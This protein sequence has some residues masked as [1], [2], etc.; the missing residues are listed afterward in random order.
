[1]CDSCEVVEV[2]SDDLL[3]VNIQSP[4]CPTAFFH[5]LFPVIR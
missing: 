2:L 4:R 1:M 3:H 5:F